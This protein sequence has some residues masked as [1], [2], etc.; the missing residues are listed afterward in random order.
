MADDNSDGAAV[1]VAPRRRMKPLL[2]YEEIVL[3]GAHTAKRFTCVDVCARFL[4][5]GATNGSV[6]IFARS[7]KKQGNTSS[8]SV[9]F[10]LLKMIS[11]PSATSDRHQDPVTCLSFCPVQRYL[12]VGTSRGAV[13]AISLLDP[14]RIGEKIEFSHP[15]HHGF[16]V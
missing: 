5:C 4:A 6:Y 15:L 2:L 16:S 11:P 13:Y 10:R 7:Q 8:S 14:A 1:A 12:V 9:T 3:G